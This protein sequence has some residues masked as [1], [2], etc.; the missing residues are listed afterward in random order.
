[1]KLYE[2]RAIIIGFMLILISIDVSS[3][4]KLL[5]VVFVIAG[6]IPKKGTK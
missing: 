5:G 4:L 3:L 1:M 2:I 6:V